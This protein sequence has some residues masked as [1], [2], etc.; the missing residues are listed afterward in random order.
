M[1]DPATQTFIA[2]TAK[3]VALRE[4]HKA[5][6]LADGKV[7]ISGGA[8]ESAGDP[9][10][11]SAE[12]FDPA[13]QT[14]SAIAARMSSP[15]VMHDATRLPGGK[16]VL[17]GGASIFNPANSV[18]LA[19]VEMFDPTTQAFAPLSAAMTSS[20]AGHA[21]ALLAN[22]SILVTGGVG[23][24]EAGKILVLNSAELFRDS[25]GIAKPSVAITVEPTSIPVG[26]SATLRWTS[27]NATT[28]SA[29][30]EWSGVR[31]FSGALVV[32]PVT[33]G[34]YTYALSCAGPG[35][36]TVASTMLAVQPP[37]PNVTLGSST[38][39]V[40]IGATI[41]LRWSSSNASSCT[42]SGD[43]SGA[44]A[45]AGSESIYAGS[46]A[47]TKYF[48]L[49]CGGSNG[50]NS[51]STSIEVVSTPV[52][53]G[54]CEQVTAGASN[55]T[56]RNQLPSG[57]EVFLPQ[58]A[59]GADMLSG[60][61]NIIGLEFP[62]SLSIRVELTQCANSGDDSD[63][64]GRKFGPTRVRTISLTRGGSATLVIEP[65]NF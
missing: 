55:L 40:S 2:L 29:L 35:G 44:R 49:T 13:T 11:D 37:A 58:F 48:H 38:T 65:S 10:K 52:P 6:L 42:A 21:A 51:A 7:L 54:R 17:T 57:L 16:V 22:G 45:T 20:R 30:G 28:C 23:V 15:R 26:G 32:A 39:S 25:T 46:V 63:C 62:G 61:C 34:Q 60:E 14:F 50:T 8:G 19:S 56:V 36:S 64:T 9:V 18:A 53:T 31:D 3:M 12:L 59:F 5:T 41:T 27:G 24:V 43:W 1:Y 33:A 47:T 4:N